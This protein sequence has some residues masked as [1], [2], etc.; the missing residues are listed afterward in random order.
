MFIG[1][2]LV[3]KGGGL[4]VS[5]D[6]RRLHCYIFVFVTMLDIL[7]DVRRNV[8]PGS[9]APPPRAWK[10]NVFASCQATWPTSGGPPWACTRVKSPLPEVD[11]PDNW[12]DCPLLVTCHV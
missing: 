2:S 4:P 8:R 5:P 3:R 11:W 7:H 9:P 10:A 12:C 1:T 6:E